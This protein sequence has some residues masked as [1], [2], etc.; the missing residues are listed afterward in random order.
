M[1]NDLKSL[2]EFLNLLHQFRSVE[3][4]I[5]IDK[6]YSRHENDVEHSY[7]LAMAAWHIINHK[8]LT[9]DINKVLQFALL[10]DFVE[11]F[12]GDT[13]IFDKDRQIHDSKH[14]REKQALERLQKEWPGDS[15]LWDIITEYEK[16]EAPEAVFVYVLD[17]VIPF[18][19]VYLNEGREWKDLNI[20]LNM[21][22]ETKEP[23]V[24]LSKDIEP[25][26]REFI[27]ILEGNEQHYFGN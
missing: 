13:Y 19:N 10:H 6:E 5:Y 1:N 2:L 20:T 26:Y 15:S 23:Q 14:E 16:K 17:K 24:I 18:M 11:V 22:K 9:L 4:K 12:A 27:K 3:R 7:E 25:Y 21:I 8:K